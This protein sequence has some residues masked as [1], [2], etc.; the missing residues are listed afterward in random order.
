MYVAINGSVKPDKK[1]LWITIQFMITIVEDKTKPNKFHQNVQWIEM[2]WSF[3][4]TEQQSSIIMY[5]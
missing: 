4:C 3:N 5:V 1:P 2:G